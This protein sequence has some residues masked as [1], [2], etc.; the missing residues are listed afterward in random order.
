MTPMSEGSRSRYSVD[1]LSCKGVESIEL[2]TTSVVGGAE[3]GVKIIV[4]LGNTVPD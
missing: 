2:D 1:F 3:V 4:A